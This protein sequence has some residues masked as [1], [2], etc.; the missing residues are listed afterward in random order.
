MSGNFIFANGGGVVT[1][2]PLD[3]QTDF[4]R[5]SKP[6]FPPRPP[7]PARHPPNRVFI[8]M[9]VF[10]HAIVHMAGFEC[11]KFNYRQFLVCWDIWARWELL[12]SEVSFYIYILPSS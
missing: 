12:C 2:I 1:L 4:V 8:A 7:A 11:P 6:N 9:L 5:T 10:Y 3:N